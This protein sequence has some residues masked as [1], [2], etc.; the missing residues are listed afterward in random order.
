MGR[1]KA[2]NSAFSEIYNK[3]VWALDS[4]EWHAQQAGYEPLESCYARFVALL[5][6]FMRHNRVRSV[7]EFGCGFWS[8]AREIDWSGIEYDGFD[9]VD[10]P[11]RWNRDHHGADNI[12]FHRLEDGTRLPP[13][14]LLISKDVLQ[15]LPIADICY[16]TDIFRRNYR[17]SIIASGVFPDHDTNSEIAAGDCRSLR[18]DLPPFDIPCAVLQ[19]WE[20]I[21]F[22]KP[23]VKDVCLV[24]GLPE[25]AAAGGAIVRDV[26]A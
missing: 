25:S 26:D 13:A 12:R 6:D 19:R 3:D 14:D 24:T 5:Q 2:A 8:Y 16:Y 7:V 23:V 17:F 15:H 10:G 11:V 9:I 20:Y 22:G 1:I 21:E 18:L 4:G